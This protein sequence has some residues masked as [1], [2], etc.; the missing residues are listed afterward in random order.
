[1]TRFDR[2]LMISAPQLFMWRLRQLARKLRGLH[3]GH[4]DAQRPTGQHGRA[5]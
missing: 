4:P 5:E 2:D 3:T 1:M